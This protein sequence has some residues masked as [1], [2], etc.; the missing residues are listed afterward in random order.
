M[1]RSPED[2]PYNCPVAVE[3]VVEDTAGNLRRECRNCGRPITGWADTLRHADEVVRLTVL[4]APGYEAA[5]HDAERAIHR[6]LADL[7]TGN[8]TDADIARVAAQAV[9]GRGLLRRRRARPPHVRHVTA[10]PPPLPTP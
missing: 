7:P 2:R 9:L 3:A 1:V 4:P 6:A 8:V 10:P 5:F